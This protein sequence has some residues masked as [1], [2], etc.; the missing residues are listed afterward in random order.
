MG[1]EL[2]SVTRSATCRKDLHAKP[3]PRNDLRGQYSKYPKYGNKPKFS[4]KMTLPKFSQRMTLPKFSK[5]MTVSKFSKKMTVPK[6]QEDD[7]P[8]L[9]ANQYLFT[10]DTYHAS[11]CLYNLKIKYVELST[12][13]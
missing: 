3:K 5:K 2:E 6:F 10:E 1:A 8:A 11:K 7:V 13:G 9:N 12:A 4:E